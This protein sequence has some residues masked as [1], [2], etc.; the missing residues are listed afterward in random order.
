MT[1]AFGYWNNAIDYMD[2]ESDN[3]PDLRSIGFAL[4]LLA[5]ATGGSVIVVNSGG[6]RIDWENDDDKRVTLVINPEHDTKYL[7][8]E[9]VGEHIMTKELTPAVLAEW[10]SWFKSTEKPPVPKWIEMLMKDNVATDGVTVYQSVEDKRDGPTCGLED[11]DDEFLE[12][13]WG[14]YEDDGT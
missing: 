3:E 4:D 13:E 10:L 2:A 11:N 12:P 9:R 8:R 7:Y 14:I 5:Q 6:V 1:E